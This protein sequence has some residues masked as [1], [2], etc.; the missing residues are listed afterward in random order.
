[1]PKL[2]EIREVQRKNKDINSIY[3]EVIYSMALRS[4]DEVFKSDIYGNIKS[5]VFNGY[6][7]I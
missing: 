7:K 6:I 4:M 3:N 1:M 2:D 5:I